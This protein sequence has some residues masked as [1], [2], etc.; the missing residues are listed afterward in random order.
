MPVFFFSYGGR[1]S[2]SP[3]SVSLSSFWL[4]FWPGSESFHASFPVAKLWALAF[5][6]CLWLLQKPALQTD[7][8]ATC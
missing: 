2:K 3:P 4:L 6:G 5:L 7:D 1:P 8:A